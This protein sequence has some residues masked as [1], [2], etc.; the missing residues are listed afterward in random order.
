M[1]E[2][3]LMITLYYW[4]TPNAHKVTILLEELSAPYVLAPVNI[5]QGD[6]FDPAFLKISPNNRMPAI[7]DD[8]PLG[9]GAPISLFESAAILEY[10]ADKSGAFLPAAPRERYAV[11]QWLYWQMGGVGPMFGQAFHFI[12]YAPEKI[13]YAINRYTKEVERLMGVLDDELAEKPFIAGDY[14]I[15]DMAIYPWA[16]IAERLGQ[17]MSD[18][19][20]AARWIEAI[21][22]RPAVVRAYE[23]AK[24]MPPSVP[25][26]EDVRKII[27]KQGRVIKG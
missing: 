9:G 13:E 8:A 7:V 2:G 4:P 14:S 19:P 10:L 5:A 27:F 11:L 6:Q 26:T 12:T 18:F 23:R 24:D 21:K 22:A 25:L 20:H 3:L 1:V 16:M 17:T 15:A